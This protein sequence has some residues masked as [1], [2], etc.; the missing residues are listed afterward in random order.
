M[1]DIKDRKFYADM[2]KKQI[3]SER[4]RFYILDEEAYINEMV[5]FFIEYDK[6]E[7]EAYP[8]GIGVTKEMLRI[9]DEKLLRMGEIMKKYLIKKEKV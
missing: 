8:G 6:K 9:R 1:T 4:N 3:N 5:D 2:V 7:K